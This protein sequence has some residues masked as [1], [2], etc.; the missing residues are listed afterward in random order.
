M[1]A[2]HLC[3]GQPQDVN[4][5]CGIGSDGTKPRGITGDELFDAPRRVRSAI[6]TRYSSPRQCMIGIRSRG[7]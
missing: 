6:N 1:L 2:K 5:N 4:A 7:Y 3:F